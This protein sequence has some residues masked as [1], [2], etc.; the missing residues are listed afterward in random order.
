MSHN[1][2][3]ENQFDLPKMLYI[4][5]R[6]EEAEPSPQLISQTHLVIIVFITHA[7]VLSRCYVQYIEILESV[8]V[9]RQLRPNRR[10]R[11]I[12]CK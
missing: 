1:T 8:H 4:S 6:V 3:R 2:S 5:T 11:H 9:I 12:K 10:L 7:L